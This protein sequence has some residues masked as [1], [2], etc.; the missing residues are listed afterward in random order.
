MKI[1]II[2]MSGLFPGSSTNEAFWQNLMERKDL[3][4]LAN[5]QDFGIDPQHFYESGKGVVDKCYSLRGGYIRDFEFQPEGYLLDAD[6]L[7]QQDQLYQWSLYVAKTAL[8]ESGYHQRP[9]LLKKCGLVLGNLSFPTQSSHRL[10][11]SVYTDTLQQA[12]QELLGEEA[13][14]LQAHLQAT[15]D[16]AVLEH[17]PSQ[18]VSKALGLGASHYALDAACATS[19]YAI[20]LACDELQTGKADLMLAGAVCGSDQLFIHMGFSIFHAYAPSDQKFVPLDKNSAGLVSAEG[21]GMVVLKRL[22]D[23][24][25]DGDQILGVIGGIG[26]SNDGR[27]K[28]LLSPNPKGQRLAFE[29]AYNL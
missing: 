19:L 8:E 7:A 29:R 26:L 17:T 23:A 25:R 6:Y 14:Q 28:F 13:L 18:L 10:L 22:A 9:D 5:E 3:T 4:G 16:N 1:A 15:P 20:K 12:V 27:G 24:E 2:G 11:A 21:A